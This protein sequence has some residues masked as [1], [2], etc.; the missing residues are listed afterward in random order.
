MLR[1][2]IHRKDATMTLA[3]DRHQ[4]SGRRIVRLQ[5]ELRTLEA[6]EIQLGEPGTD[7]TSLRTAEIKRAIAAYENAIKITLAKPHL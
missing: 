6:G 7:K 4:D 3:E 2:C 5:Q 1:S